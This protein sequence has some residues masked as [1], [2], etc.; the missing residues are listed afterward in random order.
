MAALI[1]GDLATLLS[2]NEPN[3]ASFTSPSAAIHCMRES[4]FDVIRALPWKHWS[5]THTF[6]HAKVQQLIAKA[7][8]CWAFACNEQRMSAQRIED[9]YYEKNKVNFQ[10]QDSNKYFEETKKDDMAHIK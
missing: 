1:G 5:K 7:F 10:R 8:K 2:S 3:D 4:I 6:D 9:L